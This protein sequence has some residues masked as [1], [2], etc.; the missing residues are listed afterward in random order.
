MIARYASAITTGTLIT[1]GLL[2]L[3]QL[4]IQLQPGAATEGRDR[5]Y[6]SPFK[7]TTETP[8]QKR[9]E[10]PPVEDLTRTLLPPA[11]PKMSADNGPV[12]VSY[13][14]PTAP[15]GGPHLPSA[16]AFNDGPL[17]AM[18]RV[19]PVY[20]IRASTRGLEGY[21][22]VQFDVMADGHVANVFVVESTHAVFD[23]PAIK[24]AERFKFKPRVVDGV[25]LVTEGIQ[26]LFRFN[27]EDQ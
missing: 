1:F 19:A 22:I 2:F 27:L 17:V 13:P 16:G 24:A 9:E 21:V 26:N 8:V 23:S 25:A 6:L 5:T 4:L 18:V 12:G 3:M 20:P 15:T 7:T 14:A 11:R 10:I